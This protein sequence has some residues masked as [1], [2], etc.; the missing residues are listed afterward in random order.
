MAT[1]RHTYTTRAKALVREFAHRDIH[2]AW[3]VNNH[4]G[5]KDYVNVYAE[6]GDRYPVH[7][8]W[9]DADGYTWGKSY[10]FNAAPTLP[11]PAVAG[12]IIDTFD[13]GN[14]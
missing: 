10:E 5:T 9:V 8:V 2:A 3:A 7:T 6:P 11:A 14:R 1:E 13:Q 12:A 4:G